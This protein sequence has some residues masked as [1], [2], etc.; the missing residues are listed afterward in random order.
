MPGPGNYNTIDAAKSV[1][2]QSPQYGIGTGKR[3]ESFASNNN[4]TRVGPGTYE[5]KKVI[6]EEGVKSTMSMK[7]DEHALVHSRNLP[8][9]GQYNVN[10]SA[11]KVL[12]TNPSFGIGT[13]E[14]PT[15]R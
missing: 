15:S 5:P 3:I 12:K 2:Q 9:P 1:R 4:P 14:R 11:K 8:G 6:G 10:D 7:F 13:A